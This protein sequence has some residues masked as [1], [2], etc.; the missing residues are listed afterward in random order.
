MTLRSRL[1]ACFPTLFVAGAIA[2]AVWLM[3]APGWAR[4]AALFAHL[5]VVP[6][7]CYRLHQ[8]LWP[9]AEGCARLDQPDVYVP[10]WGGHM[11]QLPYAAFPQLESAL[12][13]IPG[14]Y[15]V[16]LRAWGARVGKGVHWTPQVDI[17]DR[18]FVDIG[19]HAVIGH[20]VGLYAHVVARRPG[21]ELRVLLRRV[22]IGP[23]A[24]VGAYSR[25]GPGAEVAPG[26][27]L[28]VC[29]ERWAGG[30]RPRDDA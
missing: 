23:G 18:G 9:I 10:W 26:E 3:L 7:A 20:R 25:C 2:L 13:L 5:Y 19:D 30:A 22:R 11:F 29:S 8:A 12:R 28:P 24:L 15:G 21:G 4:G 1:F 16:W 6:V 14:L 27:Q 17:S